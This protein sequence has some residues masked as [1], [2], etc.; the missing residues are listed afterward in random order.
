MFRFWSGTA[1]EQTPDSV[2]D[3]GGLVLHQGCVQVNGSTRH[4]QPQGRLELIALNDA[5][6]RQA[7]QAGDGN[8]LDQRPGNSPTACSATSDAGASSAPNSHAC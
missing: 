7:E 2:G 4:S 3:V 1:L 5:L 6:R 8:G